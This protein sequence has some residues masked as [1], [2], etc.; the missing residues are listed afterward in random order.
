MGVTLKK[1]RE[2]E[3]EREKRKK[4]NEETKFEA[5]LLRLKD[6]PFSSSPASFMQTNETHKCKLLTFY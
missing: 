4:E 2:R 5:K 1:K 3:R 6:Q